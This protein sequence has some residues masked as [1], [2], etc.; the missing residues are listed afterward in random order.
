MVEQT[1]LLYF[2]TMII[3]NIWL[4]RH[5]TDINGK[6][7]NYRKYCQ[8]ST[9]NKTKNYLYLYTDYT[10]GKKKEKRWRLYSA[11]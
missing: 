11:C 9:E 4:N 10:N 3:E 8:Q 6:I 5:L 1:N 2:D 7:R